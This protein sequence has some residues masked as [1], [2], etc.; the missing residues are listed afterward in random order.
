MAELTISRRA[1][2]E[3]EL[4]FFESEVRRWLDV[5]SLDEWDV[6]VVADEPGWRRGVINRLMKA[7]RGAAGKA[8]G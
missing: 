5:L 2:T 3:K 6:E 8:A 4:E 7:L 1:I